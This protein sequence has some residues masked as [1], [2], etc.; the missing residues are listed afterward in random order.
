[1]ADNEEKG[2]D[3]RGD[4]LSLEGRVFV[5]PNKPLPDLNGAG[6]AAFSA[7]IRNDSSQELMAIICSRG[8][9]PRIDQVNSM[10]SVDSA[11]ALRLRDTGVLHWP[12]QKASY[13]TLVY[14]LPLSQ[15]YWSSLDGTHPV[16]S[17]DNIHH[18]F[19]VPMIKALLEF[20]RT[21]F[22]HGG[23]RPTNIFW[24]D[25]SSTAP[26][27]GEG[28]SAPSGVNQPVVF[29]TIER[30]QCLPIARGM[31][32]HADDCYA[33]GVTLA[34]IILGGNPLQGMDDHTIIRMKLEKGSFNALI[35]NRRVS[36]S[37]IELLRGL[38]T[39]DVHQRWLA[40]DLE[41][42]MTGRRLTPKSSDAGRRASRHFDIGGKEYWQVRSLAS[43]FAENAGEAAKVIEN[44]SLE[45]WLIRSL[46]DEERS[47]SV[48]ET[49]SQLR[50]AGKSAHYQDQLVARVCIALDPAAPIRYRGFSVM[51][52]GIA[53]VVADALVS[54]NNAQ[55]ISEIISAQFVTQWVNMQKEVKVDLVPMAQQLE[56][57]KAL[58]E[59]TSFGSGFERVAYELNP[60]L[61]CMS[62]MLRDECVLTPRHMLAALERVAMK[63]GHGSEPM[64]RHI[65]AF[66]IAREKRTESL[67]TAMGPSEV[68]VR[69]GLALLSLFG[70]M[71]YRYGPDQ[72]PKL[73]AW[74]MPLVEPCI[75]RFLSKPFQEKVRRQAK[76]AVDKGSLSTLLKR[77]D[78][79]DR[80]SGDEHDFLMA[81]KMYFDIQREIA[82]L[83]ESMKNK[84][85]IARD[86]GRPI[87]ATIASMIALLLIAVTLGRFLLQCMR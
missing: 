31:G 44:G 16:M 74:L 9:H 14:E 53:T 70:E 37:L 26:Q 3:D 33:F 83:Q 71:Q 87:S 20:Q 47:K 30:A 52:L 60:N 19:A 82:G 76:E 67:F 51:P 64:D 48:S 68:P 72:L 6:G 12:A 32:I 46:G 2:Q 79:P 39:D 1:M 75:K 27:I 8:L 21:G 78:D 41:Q 7:R 65:A 77:L 22:V 61:P 45:K 84:E 11:S 24:R 85:L 25:G 80:V 73:C 86:I 35:G 15:R 69:R 57:M 42:W 4:G 62:P 56:R 10:R 54:G 29:E 55:I 23:I 28:L 38:L 18:A 49:V 36:P 58:I 81:R 66:L 43:A 59:K 13:F 17:E 34:M 40:E 50:D 5:Y 63:G